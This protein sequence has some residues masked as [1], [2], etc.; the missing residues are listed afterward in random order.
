MAVA[1]A[2]VEGYRVGGQVGPEEFGVDVVGAVI[3]FLEEFAEAQ[4]GADVGR[5]GVVA[6]LVAQNLG[7][8]VTVQAAG[9]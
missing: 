4:V 3:S 2:A 7:V 8:E 6:G 1:Q 5:V 9:S